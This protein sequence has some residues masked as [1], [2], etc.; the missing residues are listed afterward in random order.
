MLTLSSSTY[1]NKDNNITILNFNK[2]YVI[3]NNV[4]INYIINNST[5]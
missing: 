5:Y 4:F 2:L 1:F 3:N